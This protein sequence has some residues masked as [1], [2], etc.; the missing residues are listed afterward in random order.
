MPDSPFKTYRAA[1]DAMNA[2][3]TVV[4]ARQSEFEAETALTELRKRHAEE[5]APLVDALVDAQVAVTHWEGEY[6]AEMDDAQALIARQVIA[7]GKSVQEFGVEAKYSGGRKSVQWKAVAEELHAP[8]A[9]VDKYTTPG[10]PSVEVKV[11]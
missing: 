5:E 10:R 7:A 4:A 2:D 8:A 9:L 11:I 6:R 1:F 3:P